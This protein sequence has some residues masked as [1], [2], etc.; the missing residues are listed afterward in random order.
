MMGSSDETVKSLPSHCAFFRIGRSPRISGNS[1]S[2]VLKVNRT[3]RGPVFSALAI[4]AQ[5]AA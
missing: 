4:L 3:V 2:S 5:A 1:R